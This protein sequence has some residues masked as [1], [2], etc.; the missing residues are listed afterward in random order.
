[1]NVR[2]SEGAVRFRLTDHELPKLHEKGFLCSSVILPGNPSGTELRYLV[3]LDR[4]LTDNKLEVD[5]IDYT[6]SVRVSEQA[7]KE[8]CEQPVSDSGIEVTH[9]LPENKSLRCAV[10][11]I[12]G[13]AQQTN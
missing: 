2:L 11:V 1:M 10:Q 3:R 13:D 5:F 9:K 12:K 6:L 8:L 7:Y 4:K